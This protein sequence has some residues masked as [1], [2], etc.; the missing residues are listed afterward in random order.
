MIP[1]LWK[2]PPRYKELV[3][4]FVDCFVIPHDWDKAED[5]FEAIC[6]E[7]LAGGAGIDRAIETFWAMTEPQ[8]IEV[9]C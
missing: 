7:I 1:V 2:L 9:G 4:R 5:C 6:S 3:A 8:M